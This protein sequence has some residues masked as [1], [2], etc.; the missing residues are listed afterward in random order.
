MSLIF[1]RHNRPVGGDGQCY[2]R[3]DLPLAPGWQVD[4]DRLTPALVGIRRIVTSPLARCRHMAEAL[5]VSLELPLGVDP[6]LAE[7]DFGAWEN[8]P[9][10]DIARDELDEWAE[11]LLFACPHGGETVAAMRDRV[12]RALD[13]VSL[14]PTLWVSHAGVWKALLSIRG[15][16]DPW[17][18]RIPYG[19]VCPVP[20]VAT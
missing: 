10:D 15:A 11:D 2:G 7:L 13:R 5:S 19:A 4:L 9:W 20:D 14:V 16:A 12:A 1:L 8:R 6:D 3:T 17:N 18:A